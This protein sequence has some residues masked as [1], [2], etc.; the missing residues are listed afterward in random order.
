M[1]DTIFRVISRP[2]H[3]FDVEMSA[4]NRSRKMIEG[5]VS[6]NEANA[7][8]IQAQRMIRAASPWTPVAPRKAPTTPTPASLPL[9]ESEQQRV[10]SERNRAATRRASV[11]A[12]RERRSGQP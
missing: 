10:Q 7:W 12:A 5:F 9:L 3:G 2:K 11:R 6:E 1:A 4:P 8:I